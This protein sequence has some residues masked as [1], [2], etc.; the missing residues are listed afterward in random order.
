[1]VRSPPPEKKDHTHY[2]PLHPSALKP[3]VRLVV[4][5]TWPS[6]SVARARAEICFI[7][8]YY[9]LLCM[10]CVL[11]SRFI[12]QVDSEWVAGTGKSPGD[13][14]A[15]LRS[16]VPCQSRPQL[17]GI[18]NTAVAM[19]NNKPLVTTDFLIEW[20]HIAPCRIPVTEVGFYVPLF[21][22]EGETI[23]LCSSPALVPADIAF[24]KCS[25]IPRATAAK[26]QQYQE[27]IESHI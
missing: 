17:E 18:E 2:K 16:P 22:F 12:T 21:F 10:L 7:P 19:A 20:V 13:I 8:N 25:I 9:V 26:Q 23:M 24:E 14:L 15:S 4:G 11:F 5:H 3:C 1:M 6:S 27:G